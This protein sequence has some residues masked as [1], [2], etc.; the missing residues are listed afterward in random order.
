MCC[1]NCKEAQTVTVEADRPHVGNH[2]APSQENIAAVRSSVAEI[3]TS[4]F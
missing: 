3:P 1:R 4:L 2:G